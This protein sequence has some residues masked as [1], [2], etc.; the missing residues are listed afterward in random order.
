M[1]EKMEIKR[2]PAAKRGDGATY[3]LGKLLKQQR[4]PEW[5]VTVSPAKT[6]GV[7]TIVNRWVLPSDRMF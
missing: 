5:H 7:R 1:E 4:G 6:D 3:R 2:C